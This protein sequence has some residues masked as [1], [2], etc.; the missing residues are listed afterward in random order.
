[1][2]ITPSNLLTKVRDLLKSGVPDTNTVEILEACARVLEHQ[3]RGEFY[4]INWDS[5]EVGPVGRDLNKAVALY[6]D[7]NAHFKGECHHTGLVNIVPV[8]GDN[9]VAR[10]ASIGRFVTL[11][12]PLR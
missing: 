10:R 2:N 7:W 9:W 8:L 6:D 11:K 3:K 4:M 12:E 1:M 5:E